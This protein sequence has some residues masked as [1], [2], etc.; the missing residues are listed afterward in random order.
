[1]NTIGRVPGN[2]LSGNILLWKRKA[3]KYLI[4]S[5]LNYTI[6]HP[7]G[8]IDSKGGV[9]EIVSGINDELLKEKVRS[10]PRFVFQ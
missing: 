3:E 7:G 2:D 1:L 8:L 5:G 10:I 9:R 6:L 4:E